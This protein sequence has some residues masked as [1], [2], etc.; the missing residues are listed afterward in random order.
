MNSSFCVEALKE[1]LENYGH[2]KYFN[3]DEGAQFTAE[4]F[5]AS[6]KFRG[7]NISTE[8][9]GRAIDSIFTGRLWR[10]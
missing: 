4:E 3:T 1:E 8:C 5:I 7:I 2:L 10:T 9:K 6:L